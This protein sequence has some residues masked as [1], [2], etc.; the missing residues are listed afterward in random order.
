MKRILTAVLGLAL[1]AV[2]SVDSF[3]GRAAKA[4]NLWCFTIFSFMAAIVWFAW[5]AQFTGFPGAVL[6]IIRNQVPGY[7]PKLQHVSVGVAFAAT[8]GW[9][10][11][12]I[13]HRGQSRFVAMHWT[14]GVT[15]TYL[16]GMMLWLPVTN[17]NMTYRHDFV[18]LREALGN[19][20]GM[21]G[22]RGLGEP[23][24]AMV[25]YYAGVRPA[26]EEIRGPLHCRWMLIQGRDEEGRRPQPPDPSWRLV[27]Q[28]THHRELFH[29]YHRGP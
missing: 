8:L 1:L 26:S 29:L 23:Q 10:L 9:A 27:W 28:G 17:Q 21:V 19:H 3:S 22:S 25:H 6:D 7:V 12:C 5:S 2:R 24:R 20:P 15:L 11:L 14:A 13:F 18:G 16:L 4:I